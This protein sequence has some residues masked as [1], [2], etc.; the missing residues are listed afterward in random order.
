MDFRADGYESLPEAMRD[1]FRALSAS[2]SPVDQIV[3]VGE[4]VYANRELVDN[5]AAELAAGLISFAT[6]NA[7][8]GLLDD[9]RGDRIVANLRKATGELSRA[10]AAPDAKAEMVIPAPPEEGE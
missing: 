3:G 4:F 10:P 2:P 5:R 7:W 1:R 9:S 8:H 6:V